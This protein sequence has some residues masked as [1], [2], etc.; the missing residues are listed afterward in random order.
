MA[1]VHRANLAFFQKQQY[2]TAIDHQRDVVHDPRGG[3]LPTGD[4]LVE[5]IIPKSP[6]EFIDFEHSELC[7][8]IQLLKPDGSPFKMAR[9]RKTIKI[10]DGEDEEIVTDDPYNPA[11]E[12]VAPIDMLF[13]TMWRSVDVEVQH[14]TISSCGHNYA[15]KA[16]I[17]TIVGT[18]SNQKNAV[19]RE[20][21][22]LFG[23]HDNFGSSH[24]FGGTKESE[25]DEVETPNPG[26]RERYEWTKDGT[27][28]EMRG[29]LLT[30]IWCQN[31]LLLNN[32]DMS[33][34]LRPQSD[35]FRLMS[36]PK[37]LKVKW[38]FTKLQL[39]LRRVTMYKDV[40]EGI[41]KG[42]TVEPAQYPHKK[43][44][45]RVYQ[46]PKGSHQ[47]N[48]DD[49]WQNQVPTKVIVGLV[50]TTAYNGARDEN[51]LWFRHCNLTSAGLYK[52]YEPVSHPPFDLEIHK[53]LYL[54]SLLAMWRIG[55][56]DGKS[57]DIGVTKKQFKDG[58]TLI[59]F[60]IDPTVPYNFKVWGPVRKGNMRLELKFGGEGTPAEMNLLVYAIFPGTVQLD[61][62]RSV[63]TETTGSAVGG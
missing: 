20:S 2:G 25:E 4:Q 51:P 50:E 46:I 44:D 24:P 56:N 8:G 27:E 40:L 31:H 5:F 45:I 34:K 35:E 13:H 22:G 37:N 18:T 29:P 12:M 58:L 9:S 6:R 41:N 1:G 39:R 36:Y 30:D 14:N 26:L 42:L 59:C 57:K 3:E 17:D 19:L 60:D 10:T 62:D 63:S 7:V 43:S 61:K 33:I 48:I 16:M 55:S 15:H 23:D 54:D 49:V 21:V 38:R 32:V 28:I 11:N 53:N 52:D 47:K